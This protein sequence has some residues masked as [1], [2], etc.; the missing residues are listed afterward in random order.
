FGLQSFMPAAVKGLALRQ[1]P[2]ATV[3]DVCHSIDAFNYNQAAYVFGNAYEHFP[4]GSYHL[5]LFN[6]FDTEHTKLLLAYANGHYFVI[7]DNGLLTMLPKAV[8]EF[9]VELPLA[10]ELRGNGLAWVK[11]GLL[12]INQMEEGVPLHTIGT[13]CDS[14]VTKNSL[15]AKVE[16]EHIDANVIYI[17]A[18]ENV[19]VNLTE[20]E[21]EAARKGRNFTILIKGNELITRLSTHYAQV[22]EG[23]RLAMFNCAGY[24]EIAVNKGNAAGLFGLRAA[25]NPAS[26]GFMESRMFYQTVRIRFHG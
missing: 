2:G 16:P 1:L 19:V 9:A 21:L 4:T 20:P 12:A 3:V 14:F 15:R 24:L 10:A 25:H 6:M 7:P 8:P 13:E 5:V 23:N 18:F 11:A 26:K 17:D 22:S